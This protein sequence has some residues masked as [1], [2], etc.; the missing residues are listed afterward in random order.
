MPP[1]T[2]TQEPVPSTLTKPGPN[3]A[4]ELLRA[5]PFNGNVLSVGGGVSVFLGVPCCANASVGSRATM[6]MMDLRIRAF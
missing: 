6:A 1:P 5:A 4:Q 2:F 3:S